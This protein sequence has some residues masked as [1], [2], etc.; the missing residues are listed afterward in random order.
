MSALRKKHKR[1]NWEHTTLMWSLR[2]RTLSEPYS[3]GYRFR[4]MILDDP[5]GL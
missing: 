2:K 3:L 4:L 5:T 1:R